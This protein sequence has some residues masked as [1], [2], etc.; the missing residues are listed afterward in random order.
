MTIQ[1]LQQYPI[2]EKGL[3]VIDADGTIHYLNG[4]SAPD[5]LELCIIKDG[6]ELARLTGVEENICKPILYQLSCLSQEIE[7]YGEKFVPIERI[8]IY[9]PNNTSYLIECI[10]NRLVEHIVIQQLQSWFINYQGIE[11][12]NPFDL[13]ENPYR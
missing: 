7:V 12:I 6:Q 13:P 2:G 9:D 4:I 11:A 3:K 8:A 1:Q 10:E 5:T